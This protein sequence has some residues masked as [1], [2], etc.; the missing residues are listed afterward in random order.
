[1]LETAKRLFDKE[2]EI[3]YSLGSH[4]RI[5]RLLAHFQDGE[6]FYLVQ[7]FADGKDLTQEIGDGKRLPETSAIALLKEVLEIL[8]F[9]HDRGVVH[10]DIK[11]ANLIRR[12]SDRKI[13][14]IDFGAVKEI[15]GLAGDKQGN[16]NM[17]I[18]IGSPGYM[19]IEQLN[20]KPRFSSDI[21]AVGMTGIQAITGS[22]PRI[23]GEHPDTAE[24]VWRDR[25]QGGYSEPFLDL[26]DKMVRYDF[27]Q[28]YQTAQEVLEAIA[29]FAI[30]SE[31]PTVISTKI[32]TKISTSNDNAE[33]VTVVNAPQ[34][35]T[36]SQDLPTNTQLPPNISRFEQIINQDKAAQSQNKK[37]FP[38]K[39][40]LAIAGIVV[41][42][43]TVVGLVKSSKSPSIPDMASNFNLPVPPITPPI[44][45]IPTPPTASIPVVSAPTA[46]ISISITPPNPF[47]KP[48]EELLAQAILL[49]RSDK[50]QEALA[51]VEEALKI[52]QKNADAWATKGFALAKLDRDS[53]AL[54]AYDRAIEL[55]PEFL[56][57]RQ[58]RAALVRKPKGKK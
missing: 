23:F 58:G 16:T 35:S 21:Y 25:I 22:E 29:S 11:P 41:A 27:R 53:E 49:N 18:A 43:S 46:S 50:P 17:T 45:N 39:K 19:P 13:V 54:A 33:A 48:S 3:L 56:L 28:R 30:T 37:C 10:R 14:L 42:I 31:L 51:K 38:W 24:L 6:E 26:L 40:V 2:A 9:V 47:G 1:V 4:D 5:P 34:A 36:K 20:G 8:V 7:E 32:S 55:R 52:D 57:A 15:G 12:N 44:S